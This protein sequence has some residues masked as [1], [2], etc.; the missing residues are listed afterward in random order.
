MVLAGV[1]G[2]RRNRCVAALVGLIVL[3]AV[4]G[5]VRA[6]A[7]AAPAASSAVVALRNL[8]TQAEFRAAG[9]DK[10]SARE[11]AAL[12]GWVGR[13]VVRVLIRRK[14]AGCAAPID[15]RID[16]EFQGWSGRTVFALENG[17]IWRQRG[18]AMR[19]TY[20]VS[21]RVQIVR[22]ADGCAARV[23]G[24]EGEVRVERVQ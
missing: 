17:Q 19:H 18:S 16:G 11:L 7:R 2:R 3:C 24:I 5:G 6:D 1:G 9:L 15:S 10:L 12:D 20:K 4:P 8:M 21:P 22:S 13:L 14:Q 23:D